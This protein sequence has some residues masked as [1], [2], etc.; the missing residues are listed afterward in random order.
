MTKPDVLDEL[1]EVRLH[2]LPL[3]GELSRTSPPSPGSWR[4]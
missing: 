2:G 3:Q 4:A 1:D